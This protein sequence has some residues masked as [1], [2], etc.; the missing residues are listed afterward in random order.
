MSEFSFE[1]RQDALDLV[2]SADIQANFDECKAALNEMLAPY[3]TMVV[4]EADL[5][6]AKA[7]RARI[8]RV[9]ARI[10]EARKEVKRVY[11]EP[12]AAFEARCKELTAICAEA[13]GNID[14]QVKA[15][16][17]ARKAEKVAELRAFFSE[18]VGDAADYLT[19]DAIFNPRWENATYTAEAARADI[20]REISS[21][22]AGVN[23]IRTLRSPFETTLLDLYREGHDLSACMTKHEQLTRLREM[24]EKR[25]AEQ[26]AKAAQQR[27]AAEMAAHEKLAAMEKAAA[28]IAEESKVSSQEIEEAPVPPA[29]DVAE[30]VYVVDF[31][32]YLTRPQGTALKAFFK[33]HGI[34]YG[35]VPA[36]RNDEA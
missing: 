18:N 32:V 35:R 31:R 28:E 14:R 4:S 1:V 13:D 7:D 5:P 19:F 33:E 3:K 12:L 9:A 22:V 10:D 2:R 24:E 27:A 16:E 23:A 20:L 17:Q 34:K 36:P 25:R 29:P 30:P 11:T 6:Q 15:Y 21:C 8:R 26:E